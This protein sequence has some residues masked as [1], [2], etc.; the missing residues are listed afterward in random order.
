MPRRDTSAQ[1][2]IL[3]VALAR[4]ATYAEAG[5]LAGV[6]ERTVRR[7]LEEP[8][9]MVLLTRRK[10]EIIGHTVDRLTGLT[11]AALDTLDQLVSSPETPAGVR[12]RAALGI[13]SAHRS[14]RDNHEV[15]AR[16]RA[17]EELA[18]NVAAKDRS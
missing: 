18:A 2:D 8:E 6:A 9:F 17:V 10:D 15:E 1:N 16:L 4:G 13:L 11:S 5:A 12:L 7:R 3:A 14:G